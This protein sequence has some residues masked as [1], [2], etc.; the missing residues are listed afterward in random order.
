MSK[1]SL[2]YHF[3][4][5]DRLRE[6]VLGE[7]FEHWTTRLPN[8]LRAV[9]SGAGQFEALMDELI[10]FFEEDADR[11]HLL[12]REL[13]DRPEEMKARITGSLGPLVTLVADAIRKGQTAGVVASDVDPEAFVLHLIGMT[14][15][16][17]IAMPMTESIVRLSGE[18]P[19]ERQE[20]ELRRMASTSLFVP[21]VPSKRPTRAATRSRSAER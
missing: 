21:R 15:S 14:I 1:P 9:T 2:L 7:V 12:V 13:L 4:S 17:V 6:E 5:K 10:A 3:P 18:R 19:F 8:L 20:R 11:A 16:M